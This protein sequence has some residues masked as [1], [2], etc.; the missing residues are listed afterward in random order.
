MRRIERRLD[1][2][3]ELAGKVLSFV[4][5]AKLPL[6]VIK[7][8]A[9]LAVKVETS[10]LEPDKIP[11]PDDLLS[12]CTGLVVIEE[13]RAIVRLVHYTTQEYFRPC[14]KYTVAAGPIRDRVGV[15]YEFVV[16]RLQ[17]GR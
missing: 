17:R 1:V 15:H 2:D 10:E 9:A 7:L 12:V 11:D 5:Y 14:R 13:E 6:T 3:R 16:R 4:I 8:C